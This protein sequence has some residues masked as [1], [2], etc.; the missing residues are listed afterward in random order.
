[1]NLGVIKGRAKDFSHVEL[2]T[3][4]NLHSSGRKHVTLELIFSAPC[5]YLY[6]LSAGIF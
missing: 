6:K 1:M 5:D 4:I 2:K 3:W